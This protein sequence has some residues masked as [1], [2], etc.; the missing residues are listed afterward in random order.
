MTLPPSNEAACQPACQAACHLA[1]QLAD[2]L[3]ARKLSLAIAESCTGGWIAKIITDIAG[4]S[5]FF[6]GAVVV[7]HNDWKIKLGVDANL[8]K[9]HG[10][11][12][13]QTAEALSLNLIKTYAIDCTIATTGIAGP[14]GGTAEKPVGLVFIGTSVKAVRL[15][16]SYNFN[17]SRETIRQQAATHALSQ[18]LQQL[19][20]TP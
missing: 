11:V 5:R 12:S 3:I 9:K 2:Q 16:K 17:G 6:Q 8:L 10:A 19:S 18:L 14:G 13:E 15:V 1:Q 4:S 7:Y 20:V